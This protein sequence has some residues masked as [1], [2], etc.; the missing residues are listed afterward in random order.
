MARGF[1]RLEE[2][3]ATVRRGIEG[4]C[5]RTG[6]DPS[7]VRLVAIT[8][9]VPVEVVARARDFG[10]ADFGENYARE[11]AQKATRV[12]ATWHFVG[13]L[14]RGTAGL[15]AEHADVIHSAEPGD[16]LVR[17]ARRATG[18]GRVIPCL[19]QVDFT[20]RRQGVSEDDAPAFLEDLR[21]IS[22]IRA[23]GLMTLPP[24]AGDPEAMR[25]SFARLRDLRDRL[26]EA[27][28][29]LREL[30]MGMSVDYEVAVEEGATM[31][32][33]GTALFGSRPQA[34]EQPAQPEGPEPG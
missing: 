21:P 16:G 6:R 8:K 5:H 29:E 12:P 23:I 11:L 2:A 7:E 19:V 31:V 18:G 28:P 20:G 10:V 32:R 1:G 17:V 34:L 24:L 3:L 13:K 14:Q 30:S 33:V 4:A 27:W 9:T 25:P 26:Q 15:V 22:G